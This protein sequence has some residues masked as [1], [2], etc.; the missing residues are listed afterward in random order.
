MLLRFDSMRQNVSPDTVP[1]LSQKGLLDWRVDGH[2]P[3][4]KVETRESLYNGPYVSRSPEL[5]L[6]LREREGYTY[7]VLPSLRSTPGTTW[8]VLDP[9]EQIGGKGL[10]MNGTHR[11]HMGCSAF[12]GR[13]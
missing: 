3:V 6:T 1:E 7:T 2:S 11:Q 9:A 4:S 10:G 8:R 12:M 5:I 13:I